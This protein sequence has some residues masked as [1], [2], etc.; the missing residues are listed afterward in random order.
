MRLYLEKEMEE[1]QAQ[2]DDMVKEHEAS[3][4]SEVVT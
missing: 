3:L 4:K 2:L 1:F